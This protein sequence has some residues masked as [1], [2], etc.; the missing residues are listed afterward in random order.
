MSAFVMD[1]SVIAAALFDETH[2]DRA[3][4]LL[5]RGS[6]LFVLDLLHA[7][8][9]NVIWKRFSRRE[10]DATEATDLLADVLRL[11]LI[12]LPSMELIA[13]AL[14]IALRTRRTVYDCLYLAAALHQKAVLVTVD[15][16]LVNALASTP[17]ANH[18]RHLSAAE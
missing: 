13:S 11:P 5:T 16:R 17:L 9:G 12:V 3:R 14:Q 15:K 10:I 18:I 2:A 4:A 6:E 1:A 8:L 7:E